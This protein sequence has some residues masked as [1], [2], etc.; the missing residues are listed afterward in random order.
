MSTV[1]L[2]TN[3]LL[4]LWIFDDPEVAPLR[5]ALEAG[6]LQPLRSVE[7]DAELAEVLARPALFNIPPDRQA[8]LLQAWQARARLVTGVLPAPARCRDPLDQKF[9][10]LAVTA[11]A[12]W[13]ITRDKALLKLNRK[14]KGRGLTIAT[15]AG[16]GQAAAAESP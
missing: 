15:P 11:G 6:A 10:D 13:L 9:V 2:D 16:Y 1:V 5:A 3:V 8:G 4:A 7:T 14:L 12:R